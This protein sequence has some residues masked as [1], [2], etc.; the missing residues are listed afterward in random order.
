VIKGW[1][2]GVASMK[3]GEKAILT[4]Q[5]PYAYGQRGSPPKIPPNAT[6]KFEVELISWESAGDL[7]SDGGIVR[8]TLHR[9]TGARAAKGHEA[10]VHYVGK[11]A[12]GTVFDSSRERDQ[13]LTFIVGKGMTSTLHSCL[14]QFGLRQYFFFVFLSFLV[15]NS[16]PALFHKTVENMS[17]GDTFRVTVKPL[18]AFGAAGDAKLGVPP[19]ASVIYDI[20]LLLSVTIEQLHEGVTKKTLEIRGESDYEHPKDGAKVEVKLTGRVA[21]SEPFLSIGDATHFTLGAGE[22]PEAVELGSPLFF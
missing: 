21:G 18:Y 6:L 12:D 9:G 16:I 5:A 11:L 19:N 1:D 10:T 13:K 17:V 8:K 2:L 15:D 20:E 22:L 3:K 7:T 14:V 4:C